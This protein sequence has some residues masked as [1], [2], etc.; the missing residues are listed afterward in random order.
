[1]SFFQ[2]GQPCLSI[3]CCHLGPNTF[4][5]IS[6]LLIPIAKPQSSADQR[7]RMTIRKEAMLILCF[8]KTIVA[9]G[10]LRRII[11]SVSNLEALPASE[12]A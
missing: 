12:D 4:F 11:R 7:K 3:S 8:G 10:R 9:S 6:G 1:M 2:S 5:W